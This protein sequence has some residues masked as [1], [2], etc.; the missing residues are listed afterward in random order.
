MG[1]ILLSLECEHIDNSGDGKGWSREVIHSQLHFRGEGGFC[2]C[3]SG[4][5]PQISSE[6]WALNFLAKKKYICDVLLVDHCLLQSEG[7]RPIMCSRTRAGFTLNIID[8][9]GL[10]EGGYVNEQAIE[11][12]K[13]YLRL[14]KLFT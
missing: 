1:I 4:F 5:L 7:L 12:I 6:L 11:I 8:T 9:P 14:L 3:F 2:Q 13:R 10:V